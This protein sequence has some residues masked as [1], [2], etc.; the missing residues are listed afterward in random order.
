MISLDENES[1]QNVSKCDNVPNEFFYDM[2]SSW[3]GRVK[4]I[5]IEEEITQVE[6]SAEALSLAVSIQQLKLISLNDNRCSYS[7]FLLKYNG[8]GDLVVFV[9]VKTSMCR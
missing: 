7:T 3:R 5:H 6:K 1:H 8:A 4:G 2:E 9:R